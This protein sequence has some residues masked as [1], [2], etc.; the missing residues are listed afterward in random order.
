MEN[1]SLLLLQLLTEAGQTSS[2]DNA[3]SATT[4]RDDL[5]AA[6]LAH[7][8]T[9]HLGL[10]AQTV[11][12]ASYVL[13]VVGNAVALLILSRDVRGG[14][15]GAMSRNAGKHALMLRCLACNDLVALLGMLVLMYLQLYLPPELTGSRLFCAAR[16]TLRVFGLGSGVVALVMAVER[17]LALSHP[18]LYQQHVTYNVIRRAIFS[19]WACVALLVNLPLLG[20]GV[21]YDAEQQKCSRYRDASDPAGIAYAYVYFTFG[22]LLCL[23]IVWCNLAVMRVLCSLSRRSMLDRRVSSRGNQVNQATS[24]YQS[25][26]QQP[27]NASAS[28][29]NAAT[30]EELAFARLM[31]V[32]C[33]IFVVCWMP[34]M[35]SIPLSKLH[36]VRPLLRTADILM[37]FHFALDPYIYVILRCRRRPCIQ[38]LLKLLCRPVRPKSGSL[39][40][41]PVTAEVNI[42]LQDASKPSNSVTSS[43]AAHTPKIPQ[44]QNPPLQ[45]SCS[46]NNE[47][48]RF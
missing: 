41:L 3:T 42:S 18:F 44:R 30:H 25:L 6:V 15:G 13:G 43:E 48:N 19:L 37:A 7:N 40:S 8:G 39:R 26:S 28:R 34:Q 38:T 35:I 32:L 27:S 29:R 1:S 14:G 31:A 21:Y 24:T 11:I 16:V 9:R 12:T 46:N 10:P 45:L 36:A 4:L 33:V 2:T 5:Q 22:S 47:P 17:W 20:F 23:V